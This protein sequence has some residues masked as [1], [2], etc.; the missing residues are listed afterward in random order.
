MP[1]CCRPPSPQ[2]ARQR[3]F[4]AS[5]LTTGAQ[6]SAPAALAGWTPTAALR[7]RWPGRAVGLIGGGLIAPANLV[8]GTADTNGWGR[9]DSPAAAA[10]SLG[11]CPAG[12]ASC[13][14]A[15]SA[16]GS[17]G[18]VSSPKFSIV[19]NGWYRISFDAVVS[20][21]SAQSLSVVVRNAAS[22]A[23]IS[24]TLLASGHTGW[25]RY[26]FV[27]Q[28]NADAPSTSN[29]TGARVDFQ[30]IQPG[31]WLSLANL[32]IAPLTAAAGDV[33]YTLVYNASRVPQ[34]PACPVTDASTCISFYGFADSAAVNW[35]MRLE[36]LKALAVFAPN[37]S[38]VDSDND[39]IADDQ[40]RCPGTAAGVAVNN[41][42]CAL[43]S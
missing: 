20:N 7:R 29:A 10:L 30:A 26:G 38:L 1:R 13:L 43:A 42:G 17:I 27:F 21:A 22:D 8:I 32:E 6:Q 40:D 41:A 3:A 19:K 31:Q 2:R 12:M 14:R 33:P 25:K 28:A 34:F 9:S 35:P 4:A 15:T 11:N 37:P 36:P 5:P 23:T 18:L 16:A 24:P 39:G